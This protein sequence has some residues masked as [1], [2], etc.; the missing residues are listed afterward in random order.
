MSDGHEQ[1]V[2][3][4]VRNLAALQARLTRL[5]AVLLQ[6]RTLERNLR[7]DTPD[8]ALARRHEVLRLRQDTAARL[9]YKGPS[10]W[11]NG[12]RIRTEIEVEVADFDAARALLEALGYCVTVIYEKYRT[13][14]T[15]ASAHIMLDE[16]PYGDFVELEGPDEA[17]L[18]DLAHRLGLRWEAAIPHSYLALFDQARQRLNLP[19]HHLTFEALRGVPLRPEQLAIPYA[20]EVHRA[21][22]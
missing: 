7:F 14:Y 2:K 12:L 9:T 13:V 16:L 22:P 17:T 20:D 11:R 4:C 1:E 5:G 8:Q 6:P 18:R 3:F 15:W 19:V 21:A 10:R